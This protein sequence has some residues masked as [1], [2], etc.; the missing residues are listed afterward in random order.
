MTGRVACEGRGIAG[1]AVSDGI[2]VVTTD[3]TGHYALQSDKANGYVFISIPRGYMVDMAHGFNPQF[4]QRLSADVK[5][6]EVHNFALKAQPDDN[7]VMILGADCQVANRSGDRK[8]YKN[9]YIASLRREKAMAEQ[10]HMP[11]YS[12]ILG[13]LSWDNFW[14]A[15]RYSITHFLDEQRKIGYPVPLFAVMGNHDN[16]PSVPHSPSTDFLASKTW[17]ERVCPN[18]YSFNI[19]KVHYVVLDNIVYLNDTLPEG[20]KARKGVWGLRNYEAAITPEQLAWLRQDLALA[21]KQAPVVVCSHIP[22]F[23][24]N[25]EFATFGSL[26]NVDELAACFEGFKEVHFVSGHT[27]V[28]YNAHPKQYPHMREHNIAAISGSLWNTSPFSGVG[29]CVDGSPS[30]Y[31]RWTVRGD[32]IEWKY[33]AVE[34]ATEPQFRVADMNA[35]KQFLATDADALALKEKCESLPTYAEFEDNALLINAFAWDDDWMLEV[36]ENGTPLPTQR[37]RAVDPAYLLAYALPRYRKGVNVAPH[38]LSP[39]AHIFKVVAS[40]A[41]TPV[42]VRITDSFGHVY[43]TTVQRPAPFNLHNPNKE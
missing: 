1:V 37:I 8:N 14:Y 39:T 36:T 42:S 18:Y 19:G 23:R 24:L 2:T 13:D 11:V 21:D 31:S 25:K 26:K 29:M 6:K 35:V 28:N 20:K 7:Y 33:V 22:T 30:G 27:H 43:E 10:C 15:H 16:N 38:Y 9:G 4:W 12:T 3:S 17:R 34:D 5:A 40:S 41:H 32:S